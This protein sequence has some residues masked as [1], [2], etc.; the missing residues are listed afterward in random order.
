MHFDEKLTCK[1]ARRSS[2]ILLAGSGV[3]L[4]AESL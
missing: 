1:A 3:S 4:N 2:F